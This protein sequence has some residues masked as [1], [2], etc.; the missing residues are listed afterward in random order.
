MANKRL[1]FSLRWWWNIKFAKWSVFRSTLLVDRAG[2]KVLKKLREVFPSRRW[3]GSSPDHSFDLVILITITK[4][5]IIKQWREYLLGVANFTKSPKYLHFRD[6]ECCLTAVI[7]PSNLSYSHKYRAYSYLLKTQNI[8]YNFPREA[9][10]SFLP[11]WLKRGKACCL[12]R[13]GCFY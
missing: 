13:T 4:M 1:T 6:S 7:I 10:L 12:I 3:A 11:M 8:W 2:Q 5:T 9:P